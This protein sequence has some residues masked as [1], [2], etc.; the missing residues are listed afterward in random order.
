MGMALIPLRRWKS[1][2]RYPDQK[3]VYLSTKE[4][5]AIRAAFLIIRVPFA[6]RVA[7]VGHPVSL[8]L[9]V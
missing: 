1:L 7:T 8:D 9:S 2:P 4:D 5:V 6:D 3:C